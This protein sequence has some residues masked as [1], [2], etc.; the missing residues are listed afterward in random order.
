MNT[1]YCSIHRRHIMFSRHRLKL[2]KCFFSTVTSEEVSFDSLGKQLKLSTGQYA[3]LA[4]SCVTAQL[5]DTSVMVTAV[6]KARSQSGTQSFLPLTVD[7]RQKAAA[8]GRI[9]TNFLR[10]ELGASETEILASRLIDRS[11]RPLFPSS[12]TND[13]QIMCNLLAVDG[14]HDPEVLAINASSAALAVS[15]IPWNG[16]VGA[17]RLG[18]I[19]NDIIINPTRKQI[20]ESDLNLV[21][22]SAPHNLVVML[23][24]SA[25]GI[26]QPDFLHA[27]KT[28]STR[29]SSY[30]ISTEE[31]WQT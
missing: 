23:E 6:S 11:I 4:D 18:R 14:V 26:L 1:M 8:A 29:Y 9:P 17:V 21:V 27:I 7:Y 19:N 30:S 13:T 12:F 20:L 24:G 22:V 10:R 28:V 5:G 3:K 15:N 31:S 25:H 16:P 2:F